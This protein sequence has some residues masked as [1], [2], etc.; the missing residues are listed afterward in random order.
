MSSFNCEVTWFDCSS[1]AP[2][3]CGTCRS[4][5]YQHAWPNASDACWSITRPDRCGR[6]VSRRGCGFRHRTRSLCNGRSIVTAIADCGPHTDLFCGEQA[7]CSGRC[8]RD[9]LMDLTRSAFSALH[10]LSV[11]KFPGTVSLP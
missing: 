3:A 8:A 9:R 2:G 10:S 6:S 4:G 11:G 7:C 1:S 5:N